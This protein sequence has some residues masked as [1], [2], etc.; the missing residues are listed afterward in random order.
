MYF[1]S[2]DYRVLSS[3]VKLEVGKDANEVEDKPAMLVVNIIHRPSDI[4]G[5]HD[6]AYDNFCDVVKS[7]HN[8]AF[9]KFWHIFETHGECFRK[10]LNLCESIKVFSSAY[11]TSLFVL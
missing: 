3:K 6:G 9:L 4:L 1:S 7:M 2:L 8:A 10:W 5:Y 11:I